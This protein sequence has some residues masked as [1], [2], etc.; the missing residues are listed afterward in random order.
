MT[1]RSYDLDLFLKLN[2]EYVSKPLVPHPRVYTAEVLGERGKRVATFLNERVCGVRGK[3]V[4]EFGC[5]AGEVARELAE[6][7]ECSVVGLDIRRSKMWLEGERADLRVL[8]VTKAS[9]DEERR[10][11]GAFDFVYSLSVM[12]HV[13]HPFSALRVLKEMT[14]PGGVM[15][16][17]ANL[18]R[19]PMAS[20]RYREVYFPW[21][22]L[23]FGD[24]VF[25]EFYKQRREGGGGVTAAW[26]N[27]LTVAQYRTYFELL[28]LSVEQEWHSVTPIDEEF[29]ARFEDVLGRYPRYDLE[30]DF[31]HV[32]LRLRE[33]ERCVTARGSGG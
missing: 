18:Y 9:S 16:V 14:A 1:T 11:L 24:D 33:G 5:G 17:M 29:Y 19:G 25:R 22:H 13:E 6:A 2:E 27:R 26:V 4:L 3:R 32:V 7:W 23:L 20:H 12:E 31:L 10:R 28:G 21:P 15:Y 8:D 30:R